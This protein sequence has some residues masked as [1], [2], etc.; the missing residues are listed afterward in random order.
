MRS[1]DAG[2]SSFIGDTLFERG[3]NTP[4]WLM[5]PLA[6]LATELLPLPLDFVANVLFPGQPIGGPGL[7]SHGIVSALVLGCLIAP[8]AETAFNQWGCITLLRNK[9]GAGPWTAIVLSAAL[10][11]AM[12]TYSWR[13]V[14]TT[15]PIGIV[16]GY[17][18][19]VEKM[20]RGQAFWMVALIHSLR[21]AISIAALYCLRR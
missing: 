2:A 7:G 1:P 10:F 20:R 14:L 4:P 15:F 17:V 5:I 8:L 6:L 21:N 11:A 3:L 16:L 18:F 12:H 9:L 19:V 13:Y